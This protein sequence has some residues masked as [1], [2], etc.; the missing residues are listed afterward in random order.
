MKKLTTA[1]LA[2]SLA[3]FCLTFGC[4]GDSDESLQIIQNQVTGASCVLNTDRTNFRARSIIDTTSPFGFLFTPLVQSRAQAVDQGDPLQRAITVQ[5]AET[6][7]TFPE[8]VGAGVAAADLE[9][10]TPFSGTLDPGGVAAFGFT[11]VSD[12]VLDALR[13]ELTGMVTAED[14]TPSIQL[15]TEVR[16]FGEL[17]GGR[18]ESEPFFYPVDVCL[19][20]LTQTLGDCSTFPPDTVFPSP[21]AA[22]GSFQDGLV[23]CCTAN[24][25][26]ICPGIGTMVTP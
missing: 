10:S 3:P 9:F 24:G 7:I 14:P 23:S 17:G 25:A 26:L 2:A 20:C 12:G 6:V 21:G 8:G 1:L 4:T 13:T 11:T 19:G 22:C 18:V 5:G 16:V 15:F